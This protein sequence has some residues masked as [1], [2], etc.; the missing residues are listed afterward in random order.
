MYTQEEVDALLEVKD[1]T[2]KVAIKA[3][4]EAI[5]E[6]DETIRAKDETFKAALEAKDKTI[7]TIH[8]MRY[9]WL[10]KNRCHVQARRTPW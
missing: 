10:L 8:N 4:D 7:K 5:K 9:V 6:R 2:F 3:K 1:E